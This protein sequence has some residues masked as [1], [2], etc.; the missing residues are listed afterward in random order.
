MVGSYTLVYEKVLDYE[1][2]LQ[3]SIGYRNY[4]FPSHDT[5]ESYSGYTFVGEYRWYFKPLKRQAPAGL[6]IA[7]FVRYGIYKD[8]FEYKDT[9]VYNI[10]YNINSWTGGI[11]AGYQFLIAKL[12]TV[13]IFLGTQYKSRMVKATFNSPAAYYITPANY[14]Q[15]AEYK[16]QNGILDYVRLGINV[17]IVF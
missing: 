2:S 15:K 9:P 16:D 4:H 6:Y 5:L 1:T 12:M 17:G 8:K 13:D 14:S 11:L 3:L 7:P 10:T